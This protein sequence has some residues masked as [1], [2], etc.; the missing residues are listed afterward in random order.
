MVELLAPHPES[1]K[2]VILP[3]VRPGFVISGLESEEIRGSGAC[4]VV[5]VDGGEN[6]QSSLISAALTHPRRSTFYRIFG[7]STSF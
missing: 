7:S 1:G 2:R 3:A 4:V 5:G 6:V